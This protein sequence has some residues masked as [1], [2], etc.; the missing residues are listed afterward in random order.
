[1]GSAKAAKVRFNVLEEY[2][3]IWLSNRIDSIGVQ[4]K[5]FNVHL[6][7]YRPERTLLCAVQLAY[8]RAPSC[9]HLSKTRVTKA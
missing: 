9:S 5:N 8:E 4:M 7:P 1:M 6:K 2:L 3:T